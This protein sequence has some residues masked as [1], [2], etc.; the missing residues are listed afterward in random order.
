MLMNGKSCLIPLLV[1]LCAQLLL[2]FYSFESLHM[3]WSWSEDV[4]VVYTSIILGNFFCQSSLVDQF[5]GRINIK[6]YILITLGDPVLSR[7]V[8]C[9]SF[10]NCT[11]VLIMFRRCA[12]DFDMFLIFLS[13][14]SSQGEFIV[15]NSSRCPSVPTLS[16]KNISAASGPIL[17]KFYVNHHWVGGLTAF[18][19]RANCVKTVVSMTTDSSH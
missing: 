1:T 3:V 12:C 16:N 18:G 2:P 13:H 5:S 10:S 4:H 7:P 17:I 8:L 9:R 14:F 11:V 6:V 19:F 15:W